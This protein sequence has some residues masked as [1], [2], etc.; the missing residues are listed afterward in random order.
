MIEVLAWIVL[1]LPLAGAIAL[2]LPA[3]EP[4]RRVSRALGVGPILGAFACAAVVFGILLARAEEERLEITRLW[5]W[6]AVGDLEVDLA[7]QVDPLAILMSLV[8]TGVGALIFVYSVEYMDHDRD[9]RRF[10]AEMNFFVFAMLLLVLAANFVFLIVGWALVGLASYLLIGY[11]YDKPTAVAAARKAFVINVIGDV[12]LV[13]AA[14]ILVREL[15]TLDYA[16][17]FAG[18]DG[19][20]R[21]DAELVGLLLFVGAAAKSAQVPLHSWLADAMEGPTPVSALIHAAT[22]VTAGVYLIVRCHAI[23]QAAPSA[24]DVVAITGGVTLLFAA[25][26][27]TVQVDIKR[28][29]AWSTVSQIGYMIMAAG[30][31]AYV[32]AM[33]HF[34]T[35]AFFKALLFL[36]AGIVIHALAGEQSMD[37][38]GGLA[39]HLHL[40]WFAMLVGTLAIIGVPGFSGFFSKDEILAS[41][42][43]EGGLGTVLW[44]AGTLAAALTAFYML[45]LFVRVF[46]GP[47]PEGGYPS[48]PHPSGAVMAIPVAILTVLS[49]VGGWIQIPSGWHLME[50]WLA[51]VL[52]DAP[53]HELSGAAETVSVSGS[54]AAVVIGSAAA[55]WLFLADPSR[56]ARLAGRLAGARAILS[57]EWLVDEAYDAT[58]VAPT[59]ELGETLLR[60]GEPGVAQGLITGP[61]AA[62]RAGA[63]VLGR[64]QTGLVRSYAFAMVAGVV[65]IALIV[66]VVANPGAAESLLGVDLVGYLRGDG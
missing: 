24:A 40:A 64:A 10:F 34:L 47:E 27:A 12:G 1:L 23:Y 65:A 45:R 57:R 32:A 60:H 55:W 62:A 50:D 9:Y 13:L 19:L 28:V 59:R 56:R 63:Q 5:E 18:A 66:L 53:E 14:F 37:R 25:T 17:V 21:G 39:R 31:G 41:A 15:G 42:W 26:V 48:V 20:G 3:G 36:A 51:P 2:S 49:L 52:A 46:H 29:L 58:V 43:D 61:R 6:I 38:M 7:L 11:Y 22:M 35:H 44:V 8:I 33:F 54:L 30:L 4:S 16:S